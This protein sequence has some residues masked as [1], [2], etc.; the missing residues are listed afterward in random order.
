MTR[1]TKYMSQQRCT[2]LIVCGV[3][4]FSLFGDLIT[5]DQ[6]IGTMTRII[7]WHFLLAK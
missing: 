2:L 6:H 5:Q 1:E 4:C 7:F 3:T